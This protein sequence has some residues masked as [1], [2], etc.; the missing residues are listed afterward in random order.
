M[1]SRRVFNHNGQIYTFKWNKIDY[2]INQIEPKSDLRAIL[3][4]FFDY[5]LS[6]KFPEELF[7]DPK[8]VDFAQKRGVEIINYEEMIRAHHT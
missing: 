6:K 2:V 4:E 3:S 1:L 7:N 5:V 8:W